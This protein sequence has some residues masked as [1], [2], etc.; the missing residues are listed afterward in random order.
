MYATGSHVSIE[1]GLSFANHPETGSVVHVPLPS[2][3]VLGEKPVT[4]SP[5][6]DPREVE[7]H[8]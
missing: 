1:M 6:E 4:V 8:T 3:D 7:E 5:L 2:T